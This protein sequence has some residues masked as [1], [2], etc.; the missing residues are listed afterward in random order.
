MGPFAENSLLYYS[1]LNDLGFLIDI[2]SSLRAGSGTVQ[3][4]TGWEK[5][6]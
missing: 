1:I 4:V 5:I 6:L 2:L 3:R